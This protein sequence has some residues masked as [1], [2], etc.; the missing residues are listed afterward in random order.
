MIKN[1]VATVTLLLICLPE[2]IQA[3]APR[4]ATAVAFV[5]NG[6]VIAATIVDGGEG[7][8]NVPTVEFTGGGGSGAKGHAVLS[9]SGTVTEIKMDSAGSGYTSTPNVVIGPPDAIVIQNI[10]MIPMLTIT[11]ASGLAVNIQFNESLDTNGPWTTLTNIFVSSDPFVFV[12]T[13][14]VG[15]PKRFYRIERVIG[16]S[17]PQPDYLVRIPAGSFV[18]GSPPSE[19]G[20]EINE[21]PLTTVTITDDFLIAKYEVTVG[22]YSSVTNPSASESQLTNTTA[23]V[24]VSWLEATAFCAQYTT[25]ERNEGRLP[26]GY[27]YRLPT[28]AEWE[29]A[30]R[31]GTQTAYFF[32]NDSSA[33]SDYAWFGN[34]DVTIRQVG[35]KLPNPSGLYDIYGNTWEWCFDDL[36]VY[37]G[38]SVTNPVGL[39]GSPNRSVRGGCSG[40]FAVHLRSAFRGLAAKGAKTTTGGF[41]VLGFRIVLAREITQ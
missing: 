8:R 5:A 34:G 13:T 25:R 16:L 17:N 19:A 18:M 37:P 41:E 26:A 1:L 12:D 2:T 40:E 4:Q 21:G 22:L 29:Y 7:Y 15:Y 9:T 3:G 35:K 32:G 30:A 28:E 11:N 27:V 36:G 23:I 38:G 24:N 39:P 20:R 10:S 6:F 31:A 33:L 14:S